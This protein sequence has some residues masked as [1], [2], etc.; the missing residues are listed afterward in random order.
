MDNADTLEAYSREVIAHGSKSF[1][2][3]SRLLGRRVQTGTMLLYSWCRYCDD[4]VDAATDQR[5]AEQG[6]AALKRLTTEA[7]CKSGDPASSDWPKEF[8]ALDYLA[9]Q[10]RIPSHYPLEL[11][12][13][14]AMDVHGTRYENFEQLMLYAY[15]VA[16]VVGLMMAH[17]IGVSDMRALRYAAD[18]GNAMQL[19]NIAR[20]VAE[21]AA[22]GRVYLPADWLQAAGVPTGYTAGATQREQLFLVVKHLLAH[23]D[24]LYRSGLRGIRYLP[25]RSALAIAVAASIYR[26][27]GTLILRRHARALDERVYVPFWLKCCLALLTTLGILADLPRRLLTPW[28]PIE[29][30]TVLEAGVDSDRVGRPCP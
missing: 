5:S 22:M 14:M 3:A 6:V 27:I 26:A 9:K 23:A 19:T 12:E 2:F 28:K 16:G 17:I 11:I 24:T 13:G 10:Y 29:I 20:D 25:L 21:D 7:C 4:T 30:D 18:L 15:R 8:A 1:Y